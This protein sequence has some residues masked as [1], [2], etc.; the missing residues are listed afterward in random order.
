MSLVIWELF[1][2]WLKS[3]WQPLII[4][5]GIYTI[6]KCFRIHSNNKL[7]G[8]GYVAE[9][10]KHIKDDKELREASINVI[11]KAQAYQENLNL[12]RISPGEKDSK[13]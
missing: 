8:G 5:G 12:R 11:L 7:A 2:D 13:K 4:C 9:H 1:F 6:V 3:L 10:F